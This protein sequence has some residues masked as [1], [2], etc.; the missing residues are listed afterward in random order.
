M[1]S[2]KKQVYQ[3]VAAELATW[4]EQA[5]DGSWWSVDGDPLLTSIQSVPCPSAQL[6]ESIRNVGKELLVATDDAALDGMIS[7][8]EAVKASDL[9]RLAAVEKSVGDNASEYSNRKLTLKWKDQKYPDAWYIVEDKQSAEWAK[10][11][12]T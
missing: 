12:K 4:I 2:Q 10:E 8:S 6:A 11:Y 9:D 5:G 3:L 7:P 1:S